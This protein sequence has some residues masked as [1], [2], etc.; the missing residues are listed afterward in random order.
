[1]Q[2]SSAQGIAYM[3]TL[4]QLW[5]LLLLATYRLLLPAAVHRP[6]LGHADGGAGRDN[7]AA[8]VAGLRH[9]QCTAA[10]I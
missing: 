5:W 6:D 3:Y 7:A 8:D 2:A 1:M 9:T 10:C 4:L